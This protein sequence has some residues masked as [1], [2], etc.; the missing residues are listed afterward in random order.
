MLLSLCTSILCVF[1]SFVADST[2]SATVVTDSVTTK[3][4]DVQIHNGYAYSRP[5]PFKFIANIPFDVKD[6]CKTVFK[7]E[8]LP[9]WWLII[10]STTALVAFDQ[11]ILDKSIALGDK[12]GITH[13]NR[14]EP[15]VD[16][17]FK[18]GNINVPIQLNLPYNAA[19]AMYYIGDGITHFSIAGAFWLTGLATKDYRALQTSSQLMEGILATGFAV[20]LLKHI[21][22]RQSPFVSSADGGLWRPFPNQIEYAKHVPEFD[23]FPSGHLATAMVTTTVI[24]MNYPEYRFIK[25]LGYS[26]MTVLSY[27]MLNNSVHWAGDYP[28][29]V[30]LGYVFAKIAVNKGR[31]A[32][33]SSSATFMPVSRKWCASHIKTS[34]AML[35]TGD[36]GLRL[37]VSVSK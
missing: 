24:A 34:P 11:P 27:G 17:K 26:L 33:N 29:G 32:I 30:A 28:L 4:A 36:V 8:Q 2:A 12:M 23:A 6:Y 5:R 35:F 15:V 18:L 20:Q 13:D 16:M 9:N 21:T 37:A 14:Q 1:N 7:K 10:A 22:G 19:T 3:R 31:V 25:P